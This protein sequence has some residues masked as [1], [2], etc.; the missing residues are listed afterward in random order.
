MGKDITERVLFESKLHKL[1]HYDLLTELPNRTLLQ[2]FLE[3]AI[4]AAKQDLSSIALLTIDLDHFKK[5]Q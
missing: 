4:E 2:Q 3:K 5:N 1:A